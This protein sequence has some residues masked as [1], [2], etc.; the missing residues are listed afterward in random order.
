MCVCAFSAS[1]ATLLFCDL[2]IRVLVNFLF[3]LL[4]FC[5]VAAEA[6]A[7]FWLL[8]VFSCSLIAN[9]FFFFLFSSSLALVQLRNWKPLTLD[10]ISESAETTIGDIFGD[11]ASFITLRI[12]LFR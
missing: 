11:I 6:F 12:R 10:Q 3:L 2:L 9:C 7:A 8:W 4:F 1:Y 5:V